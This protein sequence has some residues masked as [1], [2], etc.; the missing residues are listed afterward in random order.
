M[1][2][3]WKTYVFPLHQRRVYAAFYGNLRIVYHTSISQQGFFAYCI[4]CVLRGLYQMSYL[5]GYDDGSQ[6]KQ[7][8]VQD[9]GCNHSAL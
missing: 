8:H 7:D 9:I 5:L 2:Q 6:D 3:V 1:M 4:V